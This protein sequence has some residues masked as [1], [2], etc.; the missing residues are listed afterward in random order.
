LNYFEIGKMIVAE[1]QSRKEH[2]DYGRQL[3]SKLS[4]SLNLEFGKSFSVKILQKMRKVYLIIF[5]TADI[6]C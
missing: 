3:L 4:Q 5:K 6:V 2:A 1:E